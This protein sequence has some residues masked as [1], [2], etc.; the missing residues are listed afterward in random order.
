V[1]RHSRR[2][3]SSKLLPAALAQLGAISPAL[4]AG[5]GQEAAL[6]AA[7]CWRL[8]GNRTERKLP[9]F[10]RRA[11]GHVDSC[12][13]QRQ[14]STNAISNFV[15]RCRAELP[16]PRPASTFLDWLRKAATIHFRGTSLYS[17]RL[18][19]NISNNNRLSVRG[20]VSPSTV[21][22]I[23]VNG[24]NQ[25]YG[26]NAFSRTSSQTY[27]DVTGVVQDTMTIGTN[28][29]NEFRFPVR[30]RGLQY[31]YSGRAWRIQ[32]GLEYRRIWFRGTPNPIPTFSEP[33]SAT[34]SPT[35]SLGLWDDTTRN[36]GW[37]STTFR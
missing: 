15:Q 32:R 25:T 11:R 20:N 4:A 2:R 12:P 26:Q 1:R 19:H 36:S 37:T 13:R 24:E 29:V 27:R 28:K 3:I 7:F 35:T 10:F 33:S 16:L 31:F 5:Y 34:S 22:G 23:Q 21:T 17:L 14:Q 30:S 6:Y 18:D 9:S 8:I